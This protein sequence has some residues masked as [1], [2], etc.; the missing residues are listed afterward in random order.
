MQFLMVNQSKIS[1]AIMKQQ[2]MPNSALKEQL[3]RQQ[4]KILEQ[5]MI[6][7]KQIQVQFAKFKENVETTKNQKLR[8]SGH[9]LNQTQIGSHPSLNKTA[10]NFNDTMDQS[11]MSAYTN[12]TRNR[13]QEQQQSQLNSTQKL[14]QKAPQN[15]NQSILARAPSQSNLAL[16][17]S[18]ISCYVE[19]ISNTIRRT[20]LQLGQNLDKQRELMALRDALE[21]GH[22]R[23]PEER[24]RVQQRMAE[25]K[26]QV[27]GNDF[28][29]LLAGIVVIL[30]VLML[31]RK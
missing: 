21:K 5:Q 23:D 12:R 28:G 3:L 10:V 1:S 9:T 27:N 15:L 17:Q 30:V 14:T 24:A 18:I 6:V 11:I 20:L 7:Q 19:N 22:V 26:Q 25:L 29:N 31:F 13:F 16:S 2:N 8:E 4:Q